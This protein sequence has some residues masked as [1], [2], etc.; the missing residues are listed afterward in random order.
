MSTSA[1]IN[2]LKYTILSSGCNIFRFQK[3]IRQSATWKTV[4][5]S[6]S[7]GFGSLVANLTESWLNDR[8]QRVVINGKC[9]GWSEEYRMCL[10]LTR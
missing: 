2:Q 7:H 8:K 5:K 3:G 4:T 9:S 1:Q 10:L 6:Q